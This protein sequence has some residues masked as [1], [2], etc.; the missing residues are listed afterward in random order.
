MLVSSW[1][2]L[3]LARHPPLLPPTV[4]QYGVQRLVGAPVPSLADAP[5]AAAPPGT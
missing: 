3:L 1:S 2:L 5:A 4:V